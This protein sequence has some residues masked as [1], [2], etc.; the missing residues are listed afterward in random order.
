MSC[1]SDSKYSFN[2]NLFTYIDYKECIDP[3]SDYEQAADNIQEQ[4]YAIK[5]EI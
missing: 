3:L 4:D 1:N 5:D 2:D